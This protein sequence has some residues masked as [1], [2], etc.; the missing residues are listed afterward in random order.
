VPSSTNLGPAISVGGKQLKIGV[1]GGGGVGKSVFTMMYVT[2]TFY[3]EYDPTI[4]DSYRKQVSID[5]VTVFLDILD[6]AGQEEFSSLRD[7]WLRSLQ[8]FII[9][10]SGTSRQSYDEVTT[11]IHQITRTKELDDDEIGKICVIVCSKY[12]L[13]NEF[14]VSQ[15]D[16]QLLADKIECPHIRT[17]AKNQVNINFT[18]EELSRR[19]IS[20]YYPYTPPVTGGGKY[21]YR[22]GIPEEEIQKH[23]SEGNQGCCHDVVR[24]LVDELW[25]LAD[26]SSDECSQKKWKVEI[27]DKISFLCM[28][29]TK[30]DNELKILIAEEISRKKSEEGT[31]K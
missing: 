5:G 8:G 2:G 17:S 6:T 11:I 15:S 19:M 10:Y 23:L 9:M 16:M 18:F 26:F 7:Q 3:D 12:D 24:G 20:H 21:M 27:S 13:E 30:T 4:E 29:N 28:Q 14:Q 25:P 1:L 31:T 22:C